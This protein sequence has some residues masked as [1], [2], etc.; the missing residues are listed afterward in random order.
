[1]RMESG[2]GDGT[3]FPGRR[4]EMAPMTLVDGATVRSDRLAAERDSASRRLT[5]LAAAIREHEESIRRNRPMGLRA[6]DDYLYRR[7]REICG[8]D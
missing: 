6:Q 3:G 8:N 5:E 2:L 7:L 1:M 4:L